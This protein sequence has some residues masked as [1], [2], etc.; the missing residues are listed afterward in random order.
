MSRYRPEFCYVLSVISSL[1]PHYPLIP[2]SYKYEEDL[3]KVLRRQEHFTRTIP[4]FYCILIKTGKDFLFG[5]QIFMNVC[6]CIGVI[7][8]LNYGI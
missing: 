3:D 4:M 6:S 7:I 1:P 8:L 2:T 5:E